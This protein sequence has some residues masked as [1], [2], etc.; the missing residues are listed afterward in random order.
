MDLIELYQYFSRFV[1]IEVL[2]RNHVKG[3]T[4]DRGAQTIQE[5][6]LAAESDERME[7]ISDYLFL[8]DQDFVLERLR[9]SRGQLFFVDN[10]RIDY[11]PDSDNGMRLTLGLTI[12]EHYNQSNAS[13]VQELT[14]QSRCLV[15]LQKI[16][17]KFLYDA[18]DRL[19][20]WEVT[21][22]VEIRFLDMKALNGLI[23]YTAFL[24][25]TTSSYA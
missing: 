7:E 1:P 16:V 8:G 3:S 14:V 18:T 11:A 6:V 19:C 25:V 24:T 10:D 20:P 21:T 12:A 13:V 23:G 15:T 2:K 4:P 9:Q 5:E 22:P 17:R